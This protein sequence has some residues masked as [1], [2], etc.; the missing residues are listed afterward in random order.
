MSRTQSLLIFLLLISLFANA[1]DAL[2]VDNIPMYGQ[3]EI[4]RPDALKKADEDFVK[5]VVDGFGPGEAA[6]KAWW[7]QAEKFMQKLDLDMAMRRYNQSWLLNPNNYQPYWGFGRVM[8]EQGKPTEAIKYLE[9][10]KELIDDKYQKV[11][12]LADIGATYTNLAQSCSAE[13][14]SR[15]FTLANTNFSEAAA[16]DS[17]YGN[18]WRRWA[19]SL[20]E[21]SDYA[22]AWEKVKAAKANNARP[23]PPAFLQALE[24]KLPEPR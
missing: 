18:A 24:Q 7:A 13:E 23:F 17:S 2:R 1:E 11:A 8:L 9:K 10:S 19:V 21:Q 4:V 15:L 22:G 5:K 20:Y 14:K 3:P 6:S 12:L 16:L